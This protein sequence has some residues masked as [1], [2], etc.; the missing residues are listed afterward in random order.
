MES[1]I[2]CTRTIS[3]LEGES[4]RLRPLPTRQAHLRSSVFRDM[5]ALGSAG[6]SELPDTKPIAIDASRPALTLFL[7]L[8]CGYEIADQLLPDTYSSTLRLCK[9]FDC[10]VAVERLVLFLH[11]M[12]TVRPWTAFVIASQGDCLTLARLAVQQFGFDDFADGY[13]SVRRISS[14]MAS[15]V[16][17][18]YLLGLLDAI[19]AVEDEVENGTNTFDWAEVA[20]RFAPR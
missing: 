19:E 9:T 3:R 20:S 10:E 13:F 11:D 7:D 5:L 15:L 1:C 6:N 16:T 17:L 8:L 2:V 4:H 14:V 18:E 12:K